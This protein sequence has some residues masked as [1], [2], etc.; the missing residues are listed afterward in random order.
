MREAFERELAVFS[1]ARRLP[2][3]ERAPYL[4]QTCAGDAALRRRVE[5]LLGAS[6][7]AQ[8]FLNDPAPG[9]PRPGGSPAG[10]PPELRVPAPGEKAGDRIGRYKL[11]QQI[12]EGGCGL[13]YMAEQEEPVRRRVA[14]KVIKLGMDT[15]SVIARFEAERQALALMDHP[16]IA[17]VLDAGATDNGRPYFVMELVRGIKITQYCDEQN[18]PTKERLELFIQVCHAVQHAH[19][20]GVIH[21]DLKPSNILVASDDGVPV[22][23]TIDFGIAKAT[24]GRL[25]DQTLFTAFEQFIGTPAYMSPEQAELTMHDVDTR[26]DIY[27]LGVLLYE[28]LTGRTPFDAQEL[29][30]AGLDAMRRTIREQE[31]QRPS[32]K[33]STMLAD[34]LTTTAKRR[35]TEAVKLIHSM[36]GDLDWI[37]MKCLEK[38]RGR[39]YQ[40]ANGLAMDIQRYLVDEPV[41]A[42]PPSKLYRFHK[43]VRRNK[44]ACAAVG[45]VL[46]MLGLGVVGSTLQA[47]S[48]SRA[49][50][51]EALLRLQADAQRQ[52]AEAEADLLKKMLQG[53]GPSVA[54]G[55]DTKMLQEILDQTVGSLSKDLAN[56]PEVEVELSLTLAD[57]YY[58]LGLYKQMEGVARRSLEVAR[59]KLG[60]QHESVAD[61]LFKLAG[62]LLKL[63]HRYLGE[64]LAG[65][66]PQA[67]I[68]RRRRDDNLVE[69]EKCCLEGLAISRKALGNENLKT[70]RGL[71]LLG[72]IYLTEYRMEDAET[73]KKAALA[74]FQKLVGKEDRRVAKVL[75]E[76]ALL[77]AFRED[78]L[79]E[80][81]SLNREALAVQR[82][83]LGDDDPVVAIS[84]FS[85]AHVI[86]RQ[87]RWADAENAYR[88]DL[89]I[90]RRLRVGDTGEVA[91][92]LSYLAEV[93]LH[94]GKLEDAEAQYREQIRVWRVAAGE[95]NANMAVSLSR[96]AY[97]LAREGKWEE[98]E[99][100][101]RAALALI[102]KVRGD[103][104]PAVA[105]PLDTFVNILLAQHREAE[106]EQLL[107]ELLKPIRDGEPPRPMVLMVQSTFFARCRRW[108]E[109]VAALTQVVELEPLDDDDQLKLAVLLL[110]LDQTANYHAHC[111]KMVARFGGGKFPGPLAKTAEACLLASAHGSGYEAA[112]Q[113]ADQAYASGKESYWVHYLRMV[114]GLAEYRAG[115]FASAVEWA[116]KSIGQPTLAGGPL[117]DAPAYLVVAMAQHRLNRSDEA[118]AALTR[119]AGLVNA[120]WLRAQNPTLDENWVDWLAAQIL[121]R[122]AQAMIEGRPDAPGQ[123]SKEH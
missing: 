22:P 11:L 112:C 71:N 96:L 53:V 46:L 106:A 6:E 119:G 61:A 109:A 122:E 12:G 31:P 30:A 115:H 43:L 113:L 95:E 5:E 2:A 35:R 105:E 10:P 102:R 107:E 76:L 101:G 20:K 25:T 18:L 84:L 104:D 32:T 89:A 99:Q 14:L 82:K 67:D 34:E 54:K 110:E 15:R 4:D 66:V 9:A 3:A 52:K 1:A 90:G 74:M 121:L 117:P 21:R 36:R 17:R 27:S 48:A 50:R 33:L 62:G 63:S 42:R 108:K 19:Q 116:G 100:R 83:L 59:T 64:M 40:T 73:L 44:S 91:D 39:R 77:L 56:Q 13:V 26:T 118:L 60:P 81:E 68:D 103:G 57:T 123:Q 111:Q 37:V 65:N 58:D 47:V 45:A 94:Q 87:G 51:T 86:R 7:D 85:L 8:C 88:E 98:A 114:K 49:E 72:N 55:R 97:V 120:R 92:A 93:L 38:D 24:Q 23:K 16:N 41:V 70:A 69:A 80:A 75:Q 78:R 28:L 29:L 79:A